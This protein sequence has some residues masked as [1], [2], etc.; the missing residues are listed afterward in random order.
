MVITMMEKMSEKI[1]SEAEKESDLYEKFDCY[2][3]NTVKELEENIM[4]A[5]SNPISPADIEKKESEIVALQQE[6]TKLKDDRIAEEESLKAATAQRGKEHDHY[7]EEV[8]EETEV[9]HS[10]DTATQVGKALS[11]L[12]RHGA[13]GRWM[14]DGDVQI[15][16]GD[17]KA[18]KFRY[19]LLWDLGV[20][21]GRLLLLV[22]GGA[23]IS[24]T[25]LCLEQLNSSFITQYGELSAWYVVANIYST[26]FGFYTEVLVPW[27]LDKR[28]PRAAFWILGSWVMLWDNGCRLAWL[29]LERA[30]RAAGEAPSRTAMIT[31][32]MGNDVNSLLLVPL[33]CSYFAS[34]RPSEEYLPNFDSMGSEE[35]RGSTEGWSSPRG[36][37]PM[38]IS[39]GFLGL[40]MQ[41]EGFETGICTFQGTSTS[42]KETLEKEAGYGEVFLARQKI[43]AG[44]ASERSGRL[45]AV[46]RVRKP[47]V[48]AGLDEE[49]ADSEAALSEF[50]TEVE[51]M[52][53]LDHP[54]IC[55]LLQ[56]YED[57]KNLYLVMEHIQGGELFNYVVER[58]QLHEHEAARV[59]RQ[60][61][62]ALEYCHEQGVVHRDIKPENILVVAE[63]D[64]EFTV[65]LIDFGFGSRILEGVKLRAKVGTFVYSAPEILRGDLC[66][67]KLDL[68]A[69]GCVLF[70]LLSGDFPFY[71]NDT[72][73]QILSGK[74]EL[75]QKWSGVSSEAKDLIT[76]LLCVDAAKRLSASQ[77][78]QHPWL[79]KAAPHLKME[80]AALQQIG[81]LE[82]F[83]NQNVFRHLAAGVLAKQ[84]DEGDLHE[85]H[86]AFCA[87]DKD[88]NGVVTFAEFKEVLKEFNLNSSSHPELQLGAGKISE[89]FHS[90]DLDGRGV[91]DYTE[92]VAACLDHKV[93]QEEGIC[94]AAFQVFDKD[95]SGTVTY[96]ELQQVLNSASME[97]TFSPELRKQLWQEL[98]GGDDDNQSADVDFDHFLAALRGVRAQDIKELSKPA[99]AAAAPAAPS[100]NALPIARRQ[101][102]AVASMGLPIKTRGAKMAPS[103]GLPIKA[104][105]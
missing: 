34:T 4:Q 24:S 73:G 91:I 78:L 80:A 89:I 14:E 19:S 84:M 27:Q 45:A 47:N 85:L 64:D 67:E 90:V 95:C 20:L 40:A 50:R 72:Q 43:C 1:E 59:M 41:T 75:D 22:A 65:K 48:E 103:L 42:V 88:E 37:S 2:C 21:L 28:V 26:V 93:E 66:D 39:C 61:A 29:F 102:G 8:Y 12:L 71:G 56:V 81:G 97:G 104:R 9:V 33:A 15:V 53:S 23:F 57:P 96:E 5:E 35:S 99:A 87:M 16:H 60:I 6:V 92:F 52:K 76:Q 30:A 32:A 13:P 83:H 38:V 86:K 105:G 31:W 46:K 74:F 25:D 82:T 68:W 49:G 17:R 11:Y 54:S 70:V 98:T 94:W 77:I 10:V 55:R 7:V 44:S 51:L 100:L 18:N 79:Q 101:H 36:F 69:L 62:S 3:K 58:G 63:E